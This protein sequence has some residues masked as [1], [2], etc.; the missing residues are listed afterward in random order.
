MLC[1]V[2]LLTLLD[3]YI[4]G[5]LNVPYIGLRLVSSFFVATILGIIGGITW[6]VLYPHLKTIKS[7]FLTPAFLFIIYGVVTLLGF[8]GAIAALAFGIT[9]GN[10]HSFNILKWL[11][12]AHVEQVE[13]HSPR[14]HISL[15]AHS[16]C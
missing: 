13:L 4:I 8:S 2:L 11:P 14:S 10:L 1:I 6:S 3:I 12:G 5:E 16:S 9:L 15:P 7:I